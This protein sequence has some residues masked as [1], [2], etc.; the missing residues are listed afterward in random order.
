V[1]SGWAWEGTAPGA[2][3]CGVSDKEDRARLAAEAWLKANPGA[4]AV[5]DTAR[6]ADGTTTLSAYWARD[7]QARRSRRLRDGRITWARIPAQRQAP[8]RVAGAGTG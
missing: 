5:L 8:P 1:I 4:T 7:G 2:T 3:G 6:L